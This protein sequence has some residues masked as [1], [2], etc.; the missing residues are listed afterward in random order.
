M[1]AGQSAKSLASKSGHVASWAERRAAAF[2]KGSEG[3]RVVADAVAPLSANGWFILHDRQAPNG[4][5]V[6]HVLV[7]P[8]GVV[9]LDAKAWSGSLAIS[10][11]GR[12]RHNDRDAHKAVSSINAVI[13]HLRDALP[14]LSV[15]GGLVFVGNDGAPSLPRRVDDVGLCDVSEVLDVLKRKPSTLNARDVEA[16]LGL[17]MDLLPAIG[18]AELERPPAVQPEALDLEAAQL[19]GEEPIDKRYR[20]YVARTWAKYGK[21]RIYLSSADGSK[22]GW[23]DPNVGNVDLEHDDSGDAEPL[24]QRLADSTRIPQPDVSPLRPKGRLSSRILKSL[25]NDRRG[26]GHVVGHVW[27]KG[28]RRRLYVTSHVTGI[29]SVSVGWVDLSTG[30]EHAHDPALA[31]LLTHTWHEVF[32][33]VVNPT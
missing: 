6:D 33:T 9:V 20:F 5:N 14:S 2:V 26:V 23:I 22:L 10:S 21:H 32:E 18:T 28:D 8:G 12:L 25:G 1:T 24:L 7:G 19:V 17:V 11:K 29:A 27:R 16:A 15:S 31:G 13:A 3:E 30:E 4:G